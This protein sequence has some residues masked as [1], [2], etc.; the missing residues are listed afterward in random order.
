MTCKHSNSPMTGS[1]WD[2]NFKTVKITN[3]ERRNKNGDVSY[4]SNGYILFA[5]INH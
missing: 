4:F 3:T 1:E 2:I 5:V